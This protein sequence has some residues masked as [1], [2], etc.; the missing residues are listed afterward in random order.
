MMNP[1]VTALDATD[2]LPFV[3]YCL[4]WIFKGAP[5]WEGPLLLQPAEV[6]LV[7]RDSTQPGAGRGGEFSGPAPGQFRPKVRV[8]NSRPGA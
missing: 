5:A 6:A 8:R 2:P 4:D 1:P 7:V 3:S